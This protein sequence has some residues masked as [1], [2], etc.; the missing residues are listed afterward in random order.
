MATDVV[1]EAKAVTEEELVEGGI[2]GGIP[3]RTPLAP[4]F[5]MVATSS[6]RSHAAD[7]GTTEDEREDEED[8]DG[9]VLVPVT[10]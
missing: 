3:P 4:P 6:M 5:T 9:A 8:E 7:P 10:R 2:E 1:A